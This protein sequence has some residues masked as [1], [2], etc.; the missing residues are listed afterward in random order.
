MDS[1]IQLLIS[2]ERLLK[3][4]GERF[5]AAKI[6]AVLSQGGNCLNIHLLNEILSWYGGMGSFKDLL[7]SKYNDH[8]ID[9]T[10]EKELNYQLTR[11][12]NNIYQEAQS[13]RTCFQGLEK[14]DF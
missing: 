4:V 7:I 3:E 2:C 5:W 11:L 1:L 13:L 6:Q 14:E 12:R 8:T 9:V 10:D